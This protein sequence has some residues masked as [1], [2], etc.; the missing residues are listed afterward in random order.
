MHNITVT[1]SAKDKVNELLE[2]A[3]DM[4]AVRIFV[5]GGSCSGMQ[6]GMTFAD[7]KEKRDIEFSPRFY[8]D[9][10][11]LQFMNGA[12]I[13]YENDGMHESF[14]FHDVFKE[15]GGTGSCGGCGSAH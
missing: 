9:P 4:K 1:D 8:I 10:I 3:P 13:D 7:V 2:S 12:T 14:V 15:Q 11:A 5:E 6:H